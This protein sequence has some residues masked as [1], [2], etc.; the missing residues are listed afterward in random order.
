MLDS[1]LVIFHQNATYNA[2]SFQLFNIYNIDYSIENVDIKIK[3][4]Y[5]LIKILNSSKRG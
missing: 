3:Y 2:I 1:I 5:T 4:N